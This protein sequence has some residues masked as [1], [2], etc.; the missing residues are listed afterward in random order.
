MRYRMERL[1]DGRRLMAAVFGVLTAPVAFLAFADPLLVVLAGL[2]LAF[3]FAAVTGRSPIDW[4]DAETGRPLGADGRA[5]L[6]LRIAAGAIGAAG[7]VVGLVI[8]PEHGRVTLLVAA[9]ALLCVA[10]TGRST[11]EAGSAEASPNA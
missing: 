1:S 7:L 2:P 3:L 9:A 11:K 6:P 5:P 8:P 10:A 4:R